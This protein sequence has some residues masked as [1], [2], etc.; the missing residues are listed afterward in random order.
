M[1]FGAIPDYEETNTTD[2]PWLRNPSPLSR[3]DPFLTSSYT[4]WQDTLC[5][6]RSKYPHTFTA[7]T[8][9]YQVYHPVAMQPD[10]KKDTNDP[11]TDDL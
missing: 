3:I 5:F 9:T 2:V 4:D 1:K 6:H 10:P 7:P 11:S 8:S